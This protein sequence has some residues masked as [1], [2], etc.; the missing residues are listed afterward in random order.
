MNWGNLYN[1]TKQFI[2]KVKHEVT[3]PVTIDNYVPTMYQSGGKNKRKPHKRKTRK[4]KPHKRKPH[5]CNPRKRT[6]T[7]KTNNH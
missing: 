7:H 2:K 4:Q 5:K 1:L 6:K 3:M